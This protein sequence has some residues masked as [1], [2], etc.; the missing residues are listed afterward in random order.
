MD[1]DKTDR[2]G[3]YSIKDMISRKDLILIA[4]TWHYRLSY[5][6]QVS[7]FVTLSVFVGFMLFVFVVLG[8]SLLL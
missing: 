1:E 3:K 2:R 4:R 6:V 5:K 7:I 8:I